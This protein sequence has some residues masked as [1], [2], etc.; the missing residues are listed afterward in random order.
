MYCPV[1]QHNKRAEIEHHLLTY[2]F[3]DEGTSG[4]LTLEEIAR[5]YSLKVVDLQVHT[6]MHSSLAQEEQGSKGSLVADIKKSEANL[7]SQAAED[8]F[9]TLRA[10][11]VKLRSAI[12]LA[13]QGAE[14]GVLR[15]LSKEM[16]DTYIGSGENLRKI[17]AT[18]SDMDARMNG[19]D[20]KGLNALASVVTA[21]RGSANGTP[22]YTQG[23]I[24]K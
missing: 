1:C 22:M 21:I 3:G 20:T 11:G 6:L 12:S 16:V 10:Y 2:N 9:M 7:L 19:D 14:S 13:P 5:K 24:E 18:I 23:A 8:Y 15:P 4:A 17:M